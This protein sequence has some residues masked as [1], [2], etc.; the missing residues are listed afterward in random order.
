[1]A[2]RRKIDD[3]DLRA[4]RQKFEQI[5][6]NLDSITADSFLK[7]NFLPYS[8]GQTLDRALTDVSGLKPVQRRIL[9]SLYKDGLGPNSHHAVVATAAGRVL[10]FHPHGDASIGDALRNMGREHVFRVPLVDGEGDYGSPGKPGAAARYV[11]ARLSKAAWLN[12]EE[13]SENAV[14]MID[15]YDGTTEEPVRLPV[16]WPVGVINGGSGIATGYASKMPSHNP[17]EVMKACKQLLK[18]PDMTSAS[19]QKIILGPDFT[20]GGTIE[21]NDGIKE[22]LETGEGSFKIR[23]NYEVL[24]RARGAHRIEFYEIPFGTHQEGIIESIQKAID[25]KGAFK[26]LESFKNLSDLKHPVRIV[27]D[28]KPGVNYKKVLQELFKLTPL[29]TSFSANMTTIVDGKPMQSPMRDLLLDF[30]QHRKQCITRKS[31]YGRSKKEVRLHM[32]EGLLKTLLD[33]DKAVDIIRKSDDVETARAGLQKAFKIDEKQADYVLSLQ[34]RRLTKMDRHDLDQEKEQLESDIVF[35]GQLISD[36]EVMKEHLLKEFDATAKII[37]DDRV[38]DVN[39]MTEEEFK[40][41]QKALAKSVR[42]A[43]KPVKTVVTRLADG[44]LYRSADGKVSGKTPV[45][46]QLAVK[47][48]ENIVLVDSEGVGHR[49]PVTY[50]AEGSKVNAKKIGVELSRGVEIVG[51]SKDTSNVMKSDVGLVVGTKLGVAKL[52]K[53][54]YPKADV[55]P[56]IL[57]EE[58]DRVLNSQW[59]GKAISHYTAVF[60][61]EGGQILR[62][63]PKALRATGSKAGGV[64][65]MGFKADDTAIFFGLAEGDDTTVL[66]QTDASLKLTSLEEIP[67]K[68]RGG[69]GV[70]IHA[71]RKGEGNFKNAVVGNNLVALAKVMKSTTNVSL[72]ALSPRTAR[73]ID[74]EFDITAGVNPKSLM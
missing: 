52:V 51:V 65:G 31:T 7:E 73:G 28:T 6:A 48:N 46:E 8:W 2:K 13:L 44:T 58:G 42:E 11:K 15:N 34:L 25:D 45:V 61:S 9:Y 5:A 10:A 68:G 24:P 43:E 67:A 19:L 18:N 74:F 59:V 17:T 47:T 32:V 29:E 35:L 16:K 38:T 71:K 14:N 20:M 60:I 63:D 1:M 49:I 22:Y 4:K 23:G 53:T 72:P 57:L 36:D 55:F 3:E 40:E 30:I 70:Q 12:V 27:I 54:D 37:G 21:T 69:L 56:V 26:D 39:N 66:T 64:K 41:Q 33:I 50:I 62:F